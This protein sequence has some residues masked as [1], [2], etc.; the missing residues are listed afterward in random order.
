VV[1][2]GPN[3]LAGAITLARAGRSVLV[4]EAA[5]TV[6]GG[7][8]SAELT[9]PGFLHDV[10]S[11]VHPLVLASPFM[12]S[13]PL[14]EHGLKLIQPPMP[15]AHP[16]DDRAVTL[17]RSVEATARDLGVDGRTYERLFAP[18]VR[19]AERLASDVMGPLRVPHHPWA[20]TRFG[21]NALRSAEGLTA[22]FRGREARALLAGI[23]AHSMLSLDRV[24]T[25]AYALMLA[26]LAHAVG[27]PIPEGGSQRISDALVGYLGELGGE[28]VTDRRISSLEELPAA[29][30]VL[31]DV[32]PR[33]VIEIAGRDLPP[34]YRNQ[35]TRF[36]YGP[37]AFKVDWALD[38]PVPW[39][40]AECARAGTVH[41]GGT[42]EEI[43]AS[44]RAVAAGVPPENPYL[45]VAQQSLFDS[46]R[47][48]QGK[49]VLWTYC[50]VPNG[51]TFDMTERMTAQIER[52]APGFSDR[53]L[54]RSVMSPAD[55]ERYDENYV[56]GDINGGLQSIAQLWTRPVRRLVPYKTPLDGV[57]I[58]SS[59]TPPGGG[60]HGMCGLF[61]ARTAVRGASR[62]AGRGLARGA[63]GAR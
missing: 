62:R 36:R 43:A 54:D 23:A 47:A 9:G 45:L 17:D 18:L 1:G 31:L 10:C 11:A 35:L 33:Q 51:S 32:T 25:A 22:R 7:S 13:V 14:Q 4:Y 26:L 37:G 42:F 56:G 6:G 61:A 53:V 8:R 49:H 39:K 52:F 20:M 59:S 57:Y 24:T 50:H 63:R 29:D 48:P 44:E 41:V 3:G 16:L 15:L 28:I 12:S 58:C 5:S 19:D 34:S 38:G 40:D 27:W 55:L 46:T 21:L 2:S 30:I 60:V